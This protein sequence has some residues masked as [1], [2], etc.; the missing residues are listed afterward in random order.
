MYI[1]G[2]GTI[3]IFGIGIES[4]HNTIQ[5]NST[6]SDY[7]TLDINIKNLVDKSLF[8]KMRRADHFSKLAIS[9][10]ADAVKN[11][12]ESWAGLEND[13]GI[14][15]ATGFGPHS[16]TFA[17][18]GE[19]IE[20]GDKSVSP[21]KFSNSV[22]CAAASYIAQYFGIKGPVTTITNFLNPVEEAFRLAQCW[23]SEKFCKRVV[24]CTVDER[25]DIYNKAFEILANSD[26][27]LSPT[28]GSCS[29]ILEKES[30]SK[31][32]CHVNVL[33]K[34]TSSD[35]SIENCI[36]LCKNK[37]LIIND[38]IEKEFS[39]ILGNMVTANAFGLIEGSIM[40]KEANVDNVKCG[41]VQLKKPTLS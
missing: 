25:G 40:L 24:L 20:Y 28:E 22:H 10:V 39:S 3:G 35:I 34:S 15:L 1:T 19:L 5:Y 31:T 4:L 41:T 21:I 18:L 16:T 36:G 13:T 14:I 12:G 32:F 29:F 26:N 7:E 2:L 23:L 11:C 17:F 8:R 37:S 9:S 27:K 33:N 38:T 30:K 6:I